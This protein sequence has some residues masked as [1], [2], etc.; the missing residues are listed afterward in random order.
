MCKQQQW[1]G[2]IETIL[3]IIQ[4]GVPMQVL[5]ELLVDLGLTKFTNDTETTNVSII[6]REV[7]SPAFCFVFCWVL[8]GMGIHSKMIHT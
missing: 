5:D 1:I 2:L 4:V 6:G 8:F 3:H 7:W